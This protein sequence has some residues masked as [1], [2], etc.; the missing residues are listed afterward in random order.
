MHSEVESAFPTWPPHLQGYELL[1]I[2]S[3]WAEHPSALTVCVSRVAISGYCAW[4]PWL[5]GVVLTLQTSFCRGSPSCYICLSP[6]IGL[7]FPLSSF[8]PLHPPLPLLSLALFPPC[9]FPL[10]F[11]P[12]SS[13]CAFCLSFSPSCVHSHPSRITPSPVT[14]VRACV[15]GK[16]TLLL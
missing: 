5:E 10:S 2:Q 11:S 7:S 1:R 8:F 16:P 14:R 9:L 4:W 3:R 6:C 12:L 15:P 13:L